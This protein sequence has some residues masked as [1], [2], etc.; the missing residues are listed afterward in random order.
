MFRKLGGW[1]FSLIK[2]NR[3]D[4][5]HTILL[6]KLMGWG[7]PNEVVNTVWQRRMKGEKAVWAFRLGACMGHTV[8]WGTWRRGSGGEGQKESPPSGLWTYRHTK[9]EQTRFY[10]WTVMLPCLYARAGLRAHV[11]LDQTYP[12]SW[13]TLSVSMRNAIKNL[14]FL[15]TK[16]M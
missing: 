6:N 14:T 4:W 15:K 13:P 5:Y 16:T 7:L 2:V 8:P 10:V 3:L 12:E 9:K 1:G 11:R